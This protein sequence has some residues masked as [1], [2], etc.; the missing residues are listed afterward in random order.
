[1]SGAAHVCQIPDVGRQTREQATELVAVAPLVVTA[2]DAGTLVG[3]CTLVT[4]GTK[5]IAFSSAELLR[6][7]PDGLAVALTMDGKTTVPVTQWIAGRNPGVGIIE[8][9]APYPKDKK[10][11]VVPLEL[12][13]ISA[14]VDTRGAPSALVTIV[15]G[16]QRFSRRAVPV[17]VDLVDG[18]GMSD[19]VLAKLA[20]P[21]EADDSGAVV[22]GAA[23]FSW[24]PADAVLG[25]PPE[26]VAVALAIAYRNTQFKP[27]EQAA[28]AELLGLEDLG[29]AL[30]FAGAKEEGSNELGQIAGEIKVDS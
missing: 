4:N 2:G 3:P 6:N 1:L 15:S 14:T 13:A 7:A 10:L 28:I 21:M 20:S 29:R 22:D 27:R 25:R 16:D 30:P 8:L 12:G 5:T 19:D 11:D 18:A 23:L 26:V 24:L 17:H 9:G